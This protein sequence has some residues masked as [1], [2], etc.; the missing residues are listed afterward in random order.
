M[1]NKPVDV[2][3]LSECFDVDYEKGVLYWKTER[4]SHHFKKEPDRVCWTTKYAGKAAGGLVNTNTH[5]YLAVKISRN[6][7]QS[8]TR[9]TVLFT[10]CT[11]QTE[12]RRM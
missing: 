7:R 12:M 10:H 2:K 1:K 3:F 8:Y 4:P 9:Y 11:I 6:A 5:V